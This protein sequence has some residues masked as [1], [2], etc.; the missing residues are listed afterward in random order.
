MYSK[1][2]NFFAKTFEAKTP[3][4]EQGKHGSLSVASVVDPFPICPVLYMYLLLPPRRTDDIYRWRQ[5][6]SLEAPVL[7]DQVGTICSH[8]TEPCL[9]AIVSNRSS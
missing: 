3:I 5:L 7:L 2:N 9:G 1:E 8:A 4:N 6:A